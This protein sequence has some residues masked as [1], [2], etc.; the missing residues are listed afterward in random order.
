M[1]SY[2]YRGF[3]IQQ[4]NDGSYYA[5]LSKSRMIESEYI[6]EIKVMIDNA[7]DFNVPPLHEN[8]KLKPTFWER[9]IS[10]K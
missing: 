3:C 5:R 1:K 7:L 2:F 6:R 10:K 8:K 9:Q 4:K